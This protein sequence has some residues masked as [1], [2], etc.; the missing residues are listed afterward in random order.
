MQ[1]FHKL[2]C[3]A[4]H[5]ITHLFC[6]ATLNGVLGSCSK[7]RSLTFTGGFLSPLETPPPPPHAPAPNFRQPC[8]IFQILSYI[9]ACQIVSML[10][11][12]AHIVG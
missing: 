4:I 7:L 1:S 6:P 3:C 10:R 12:F 8:R 11:F 9:Q 5:T 2:L